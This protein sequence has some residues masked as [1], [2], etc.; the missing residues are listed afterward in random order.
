MSQYKGSIVVYPTN[1]SM[2]LNQ[3]FRNG[4]HPND[5]SING[6]NEGRV[7]KRLESLLKAKGIPLDSECPSCGR[8]STVHGLI[9]D[10]SNKQFFVCPGDYIETITTDSGIKH[11]KHHSRSI[12][13]SYF[14]TTEPLPI[15]E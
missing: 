8:L 1:S 3:W 4:D 7:V 2:V 13:E 10:A 12:I 11:Y 9:I 14:T 5:F 15:T 6:L